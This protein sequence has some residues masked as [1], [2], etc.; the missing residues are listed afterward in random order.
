MVERAAGATAPAGAPTRSDGGRD[1]TAV[2]RAV[3]RFQNG[4]DREAAFRLLYETF[5]QPLRRFFVRQGASPEDALDLTQQ[6]MLRV[7]QGLEG[8][9]HRQRFTA[10]LFQVARNSFLKWR[11]GQ[12]AAKRS[13]V[14]ISTDEIE[15]PEAAMAIAGKQLDGM[16]DDE[17]R[18]ALAAAVAELPAQMR[19]CLTLRLCHQLSYR[20]IATVKRL[21]A[22]AVKAHLFRARKRLRERLSGFDLGDDDEKGEGER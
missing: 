20:E 14:E 13:A 9:E 5:F 8:Y 12:A 19:D 16:V 6:T 11:R 3:C 2:D 22:E 10:W 21:S 7:Y 4:D 15:N 1:E 17:R 18:R